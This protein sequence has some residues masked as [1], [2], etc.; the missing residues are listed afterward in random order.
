M[1]H[2]R[3]LFVKEHEGE[4]CNGFRSRRWYSHGFELF[5]DIPRNRSGK[6]YPVFLGLIRNESKVIQSSLTK[7]LTTKQISEISDAI[8]GIKNAVCADFPQ[9][10]HQIY[11]AHIKRHM[12]NCAFHKDKLQMSEELNKVFTLESKEMNSLLGY[13]Q[14]ITFVAKWEKK[15]PIL[16][17]YKADR[18]IAYFTYMDLSVQVQRSYIRQI[19]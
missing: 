10:S 14:F 11:V 9:A 5:L 4:Q 12:L 18:N 19:G 13:E 6:F 17:K 16:K 3:K 15:Y 2:E 1:N 8:K 7:G